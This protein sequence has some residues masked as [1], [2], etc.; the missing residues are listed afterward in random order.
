MQEQ[1]SC[2][3]YFYK[4]KSILFRIFECVKIFEEQANEKE[5]VQCLFPNGRK[6]GCMHERR[7]FLTINVDS[8][9]ECRKKLSKNWN[10]FKIGVKWAEK[11]MVE[12]IA[13]SKKNRFKEFF[14]LSQIFFHF[15]ILTFIVNQLLNFEL[16]TNGQISI[17]TSY[18]VKKT[19]GK[20]C[21]VSMQCTW[22]LIYPYGK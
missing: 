12:Y 21:S 4:K 7:F 2:K 5:S 22:N 14:I 6:R 15:T 11:Q 3:K 8:K 18:D 17:A 9:L 10:L 1:H 19:F 16:K 20:Y 13:E